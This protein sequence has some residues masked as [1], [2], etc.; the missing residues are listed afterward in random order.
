MSHQEL[1]QTVAVLLTYWVDVLALYNWKIDVK[2]KKNGGARTIANLRYLHAVMHLPITNNVEEL[3][4]YIVHECLHLVFFE[5]SLHVHLA[6]D[7]P[8]HIKEAVGFYEDRAIEVLARALIRLKRGKNASLIINI[9]LPAPSNGNNNH[10]D[11][12]EGN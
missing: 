1:V 8:L 7:V 4:G 3:E 5:A 11:G 6:Q 2:L 9:K 10:P 12:D